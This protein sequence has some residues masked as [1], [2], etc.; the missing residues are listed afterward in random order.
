MRKNVF[1]ATGTVMIFSVM[2]LTTSCAQKMVQTEPISAT[3]QEVSKDIDQ[4]RQPQ[5]VRLRAEKDSGEVTEAAFVN[6]SVHFTF[7]SALLSDQAQLILSNKADYLSTH[8]EVMITVEGHCDERGTDAYNIALGER[9]AEAVKNFLVDLGI[10]ANRLNTIS[11][12]EERPITL[13]QNE[14]S[15]AK[16]RRAQLVNN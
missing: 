10:S 1:L 8:S 14:S 5:E 15:W 6:E 9:R 11:Y 4:D 16:N 7:D 12:G 3:Q 2:I 13:G